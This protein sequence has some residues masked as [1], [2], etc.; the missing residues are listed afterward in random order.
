MTTAVRTRDLQRVHPAGTCYSLSCNCD[1]EDRGQQSEHP[2]AC[3][4]LREHLLM[5]T[6]EVNRTKERLTQFA[7]TSDLELAAI[8]VE[9]GTRSPA[10]FGRLLDTVVRDQIERVLLPSMLHFAVLGSPGRIRDYFEA[11]TGAQVLTMP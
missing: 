1:P 8:F 4:Y 9:E 10:A 2:R 11:A 5:C 7:A 3:A 6:S